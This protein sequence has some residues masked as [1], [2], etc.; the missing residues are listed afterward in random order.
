MLTSASGTGT[1]PGTLSCVRSIRIAAPQ[2]GRVPTGTESNAKLRAEIAHHELRHSNTAPARLGQVRAVHDFGAGDML[3]IAGP[4]LS[5]PVML[6]FTFEWYIKMAVN[7]PP[8][9]NP[10][11]RRRSGC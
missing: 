8:P 10:A 7:V 9:A 1:K 4:G 6:P 5:Q 3:E 2:N 11:S